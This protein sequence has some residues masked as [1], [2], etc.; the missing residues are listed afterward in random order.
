[1]KLTLIVISFWS[2]FFLPTCY[3]E[4]SNKYLKSYDQ[5][6]ES[7]HMINWDVNKLYGFVMS[8]FLPISGFKLMN[9]KTFNIIK[10]TNNSSK[11]YVLKVDLEYTKGLHEFDN[12]YHLKLKK[13]FCLVIN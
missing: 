7:K 5:K 4:A 12:K 3:S 10:Y 2:S 1:M 11:W 6:Q 13:K 9:S 8:K